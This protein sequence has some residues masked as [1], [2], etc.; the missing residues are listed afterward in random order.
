M[1]F[2]DNIDIIVYRGGTEVL[3]ENSIQAI[4]ESL[5]ELPNALIELDLQ[6]TKDFEMF[7]EAEK[8]FFLKLV[9]A[10]IEFLKN[11]NGKVTKL[12]LKQN[13]QVIVALKR[14]I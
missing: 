1:I 10:S 9:E 3:P 11:D 4:V 12:V 7:A 14:K 2:D 5:K 6:I 8:K 13:G